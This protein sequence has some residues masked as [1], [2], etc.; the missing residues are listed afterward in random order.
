MSKTG[1]G[2]AGVDATADHLEVLTTAIAQVPAG[3]RKKLLVRQIGFLEA[4]HRAHARVW[5][6]L[7]L[8]GEPDPGRQRLRPRPVPLRKYPIITAW[9]TLVAVAADL[10]SWLRLLSLP[11]ALNACE[12]KALRYRF[13]HVQFA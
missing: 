7:P 6:R 8:A 5:G 2:N 4:R 13:L 3:H 10:I 11:D 1:C 12:P 9:L